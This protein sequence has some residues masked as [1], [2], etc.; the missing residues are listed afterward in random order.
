[1]A[2]RTS[3]SGFTFDCSD[4]ARLARFWAELLGLKLPGSADDPL[5]IS[6]GPDR[7]WIWFQKVPEP[8]VAK[9]RFHMD[10]ETDDLAAELARAQSLGATVVASHS[11]DAWSWTVLQDPEGNEFCLRTRVPR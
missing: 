8:K 5:V 7:S 10:L 6:D 9:N 1:M 4:P 3:I 11:M 2:P